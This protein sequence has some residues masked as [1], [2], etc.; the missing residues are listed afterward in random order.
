MIEQLK[1]DLQKALTEADK[2]IAATSVDALRQA[3]S[4]L[5]GKEGSLGRLLA[6]IGKLPAE[7]RG[8]AGKEIN[9]AKKTIVEKFAAAREAK[10]KS[11]DQ[12]STATLKPMTRRC[13][14]PWCRRAAFI[15]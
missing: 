1:A 9:L 3:E 6:S 11:S 2:L 10:E 7:V 15:R 8:P 5:T 14:V 13:P 12:Q 4:R